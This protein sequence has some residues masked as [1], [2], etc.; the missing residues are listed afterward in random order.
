MKAR[1]LPNATTRLDDRELAG[2][3]L[4]TVPVPVG[5]LFTPPE[6]PVLSP[7]LLPVLP[8]LPLLLLLDPEEPELEPEGEAVTGQSKMQGGIPAL[9]GAVWLGQTEVEELE[10]L[11][12]QFEGAQGWGGW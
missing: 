12:V 5:L 8:V 10:V 11:G 7:L 2:D 9:A 4:V 1:A 3:A 6:V